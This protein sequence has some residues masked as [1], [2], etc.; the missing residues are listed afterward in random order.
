LIPVDRMLDERKKW[1]D[2]SGPRAE[3][4]LSTR[5]RLARNISGARFVGRAPEDELASI[6]QRAAG[7][8]RSSGRMERGI[9]SPI[10]ELG[11]LD[12]QFLLERHILSPDL[13]AEAKH[14]GIAVAADESLS[15]MINEEDHLRLQCMKSGMQFREA[16]TDVS[17]LDDE[18]G[19]EIPYAFSEDLG[20]LTSC[21]TNVG[22]GMRASVLVH[23][24]SLVLTQR[25]KNVLAGVTQ[26][27]FSVRGFHG[28]G[29][30][31]VGNFFQISN[32]VTLGM[33]EGTTLEKLQEVVL[34]VMEMESRACE[35]LLRDARVQIEDKI[36][37]AFATLKYARVLSSQECMGLLSA[38]RFGVTIGLTNL[39]DIGTLNEILLYSQPA[40]VQHL[41]GHAMGSAE[42][43][44]FR[45]VWI[46][47]RLN[48]GDVPR[49]P[50]GI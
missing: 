27:G 16:W 31:V 11:V 8:V 5:V 21:P 26:V 32:Q 13:T 20:F 34:Q 42:R 19:A 44:E 49:V 45:A 41:A 46:Q 14:R 25:A 43:N 2:G 39:P 18:V 33:A 12:R 23:L 7:A 40:H 47:Q 9:V 15:V 50:D 30:D 17:L 1:F 24:P 36:S 37:R 10:D 35:A 38:V 48:V 3:S 28:E 6:Y 22:T 29:S 4:I